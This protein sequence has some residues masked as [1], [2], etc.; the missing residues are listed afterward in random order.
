[1]D[2]GTKGLALITYISRIQPFLFAYPQN[3]IHIKF[4]T[5]KLYTVYNLRISYIS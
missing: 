3:V 2:Q 4:L 5:P 1:M